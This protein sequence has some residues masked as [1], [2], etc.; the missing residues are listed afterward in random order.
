MRGE[1][2]S[3][4]YR[5]GHLNEWTTADRLLFR[6]PPVEESCETER[7]CCEQSSRGLTLNPQADYTMFSQ[8]PEFE[9]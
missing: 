4:V 2:G 6:I 7:L 8:V 3:P 5:V 9:K 1:L